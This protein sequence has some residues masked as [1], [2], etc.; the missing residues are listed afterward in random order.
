MPSKYSDEEL[1]EHRSYFYL[2]F[3]ERLTLRY[4]KSLSRREF[5]ALYDAKFILLYPLSERKQFGAI[6]IN[7]RTVLVIKD[8]RAKC[9]VTCLKHKGLLPVPIQYRRM[10]IK[11]EDFTFQLRSKIRQIKDRSLAMG[12]YNGDYREWFVVDNGL[13]KWEKS[14]IYFYHK[15]R[16]KNIWLAKIVK[17]LYKKEEV[18]RNSP[19]EMMQKVRDILV[20]ENEK[21]TSG[22]G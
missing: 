2:H 9:M 20:A 13:E 17:H 21:Q 8:K 3:N 18:E 5:D 11:G 19:L 14:A 7:G 4:K 16:D 1:E 15:G 10:H 12:K 6:K 22:S